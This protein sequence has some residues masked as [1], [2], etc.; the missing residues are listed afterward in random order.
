M[1][2]QISNLFYCEH[3]NNSAEHSHLIE[4]FSATRPEGFGLEN[5][6][7][8]FAIKDELS[9]CSRT[10]LVRDAVN[11]DLVGYFSLKAGSITVN[12]KRNYLGSSFDTVPGIE[13]ANFAVNGH[14]K[15][16]HTE[17]TGIGKAIFYYFIIP[18]ACEAARIIGASILY[19][20]ALNQK[21]LIKHYETLKFERLDKTT[22]RRLHRRIKPRYD[23]HCIFMYQIL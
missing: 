22:E 1:K 14:Y 20:Y 7:K 11:G 10:Y 17:L 9:G 19:I 13:L 23:E 6:L 16:S 15:E 18:R 4:S 2:N 5:Y 8:N 21:G 12:E 3:L